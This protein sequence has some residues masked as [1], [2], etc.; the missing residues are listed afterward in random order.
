M[1]VHKH[2]LTNSITIQHSCIVTTLLSLFSVAAEVIQKE[3]H[4][5]AGDQFT[6]QYPSEPAVPLSSILLSQLPLQ[7]DLEFLKGKLELPI[8]HSDFSIEQQDD[9]SAILSISKPMCNTG[10]VPRCAVLIL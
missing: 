1:L 8:G 7:V 4:D 5:I 10:R 6:V 9:C 2:Q 3:S